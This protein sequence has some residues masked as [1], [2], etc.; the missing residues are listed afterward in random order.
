LWVGA[1]RKAGIR[2]G[3]LVGA[4]TGEA[5]LPS[6]ILGAIEIRDNFS[7]VEVPELHADEI[8]A[9]LKK[10]S[11]RGKKVVIRRDRDT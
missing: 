8:V 9:A 5:G 2:P 11:I 6:T 4:I 7:L 1:G 10:S 3:D